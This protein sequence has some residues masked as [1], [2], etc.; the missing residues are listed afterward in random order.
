METVIYSCTLFI[1]TIYL[2]FSTISFYTII[3]DE[4][5]DKVLFRLSK[6]IL[7]I[8]IG[9]F[10]IPIIFG[11]ELGEDFKDKNL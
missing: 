1:A 8:L 3:V 10:F 9:W 7:S 11:I 2:I 4:G 6:G 5:N